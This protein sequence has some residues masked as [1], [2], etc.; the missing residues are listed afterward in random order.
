MPT[1][2]EIRRVSSGSGSGGSGPGSVPRLI[3]REVTLTLVGSE[4]KYIPINVGTDKFDIRTILVTND[5]SNL[6]EVTIKDK[7]AGG[8]TV[9]TSLVESRTYDILN[10]PSSDKEGNQILHLFVEN[11]ASSSSLF[12]IVVKLTNLQ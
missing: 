5:S 2:M 7:Q 1:S 10:I 6:A 9:Y 3:E 8:D 11:R 4:L 12:R